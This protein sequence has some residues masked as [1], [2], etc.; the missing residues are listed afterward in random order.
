MG[1]ARL[2]PKILHISVE[3]T[4]RAWVN[5]LGFMSNLEELVISNAQP[6]SLGAK[7]LQSFI[8]QPIIPGAIS[9]PGESSTP[10]CPLLRRFVLKYRRWLRPSEE[11][12]LVP[13][14]SSMIKSRHYSS[15]PLRSFSLWITDYQENPF[16]LIEGS[17]TSYEGFDHL[18]RAM[19]HKWKDFDDFPLRTRTMRRLNR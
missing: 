12:D 4:N 11:F 5:A 9:I 6:S 8:I 17:T 16:E 15:Y 2:T 18:R 10:L 19:G 14:F 13:V 3:A 7:V 1:Q